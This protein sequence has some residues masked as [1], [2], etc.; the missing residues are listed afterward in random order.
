MNLT[1]SD[2]LTRVKKVSTFVRG[3]FQTLMVLVGIVTFLKLSVLIF[4]PESAIE[5]S[6]SGV[7]I[8]AD[9]TPSFRYRLTL[10][11]IVLTAD[12]VQTPLRV[13]TGI[14]VVVSL[15]VSLKILQHL[16]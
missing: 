3:A 9:S 13:F 7:T 14:T 2:Q 1:T 11:D 10:L 5:M 4:M 16:V 8:E 6:D 12:E 15:L